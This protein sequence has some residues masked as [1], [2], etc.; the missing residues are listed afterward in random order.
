MLF[1]IIVI[2]LAI[3]LLVAAFVLVR[4]YLFIQRAEAANSIDLPAVEVPEL[5]LDKEESAKHLSSLIQIET[6]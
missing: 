1:P 3:L 6:I 4:T 2:I 5:E